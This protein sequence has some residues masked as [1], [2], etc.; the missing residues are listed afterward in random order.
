MKKLI[1][2]LVLT[3]FSVISSFAVSL[4]DY[5]SAAAST[6][7]VTQQA[8]TTLQANAA[9]IQQQLGLY[10][11]DYIGTILDAANT[12]KLSLNISATEEQKKKLIT[13]FLTNLLLSQD[14]A[15]NIPVGTSA[16]FITSQIK[17]RIDEVSLS[18]KTGKTYSESF[19][20]EGIFDILILAAM[21][22]D[23][24]SKNL[25]IEDADLAIM[26]KLTHAFLK[27]IV[28]D[29]MV[30]KIVSGANW[31]EKTVQTKCPKC[32]EFCQSAEKGVFKFIGFAIYI[33]P[34]V[35][36]L[37]VTILEVRSK[38]AAGSNSG[39][40]TSRAPAM[41]EMTVR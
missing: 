6:P 8:A 32:F 18:L 34:I 26:Y 3:G 14:E 5:A 37:I 41:I 19:K 33:E 35:K 31:M 30:P 28:C 12:A 4:T 23:F 15:I 9:G 2:T 40:S 11:M 13:D 1:S 16:Q 24:E 25:K 22:H 21:K 38:A 17:S 29:Q 10:I 36:E 7:G 39:A 27:P 20:T